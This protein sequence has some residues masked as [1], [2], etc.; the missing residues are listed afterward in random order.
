MIGQGRTPDRLYMEVPLSAH[1]A[2][3]VAT[4]AARIAKSLM[5]KLS[6]ASAAGIEPLYGQGY[7]GIR[8][9]REYVWYQN[10]GIGP[11]TMRSLAGKVIPMWIDDPTGKERQENPKAKTRTTA[12]GKV[13]V[14]IFRKAA[15]QGQRRPDGKPASYPGAP[16]RIAL[17]EAAKP[18]TATGKV[19]GRIAQGNVGVRWRHPGLDRREFLEESLIRA[20]Q[21]HT[22]VPGALHATSEAWHGEAA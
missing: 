14:L 20:C 17:R 19:G 22:V 1:E 6:G 13:Q 9:G 11:F 2:R 12:S 7:I 21:A 18:W 5:P 15:K 8:W 3:E 4:D 16:G 10:A